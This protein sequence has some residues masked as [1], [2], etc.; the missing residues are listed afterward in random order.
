MTRIIAGAAGG[1]RLQTP[2]GSDTRPTSDRVR[3]ALFSRLEHLQAIDGAA[4]LDLYAGSGAL[5]LEALSRG[6][7]RVVLVE[8]A[9]RAAAVARRNA[10]ET[11]AA[12]RAAR[13]AEAGGDRG[14]DLVA[15]RVASVARYLAGP[16]EADGPNDLVFLDPPYGLSEQ[17]LARALQ[18]LA[19]AH[20]RP[21]AL[22]VV[23][24]SA[25][26]PEPTWPTGSTGSGAL[27]PS[28]ARSYGETRLWFAEF[29]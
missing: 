26:S 3:E 13:A 24:R 29:A 16:G 1:R 21:G 17:E 9:R 23:E 25:R 27:R 2:P 5:G 12:V 4:V 7:R 8:Q 10:A 18:G 19:D 20:L 11:A 6:A 15:V 28:E 14:A 22:V